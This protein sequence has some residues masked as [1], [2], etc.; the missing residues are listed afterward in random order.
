M[1][2]RPRLTSSAD[3]KAFFERVS[4]D[5]GTGTGFVA[6]GLASRAASV[7]GVDNSPAM[8]ALADDNLADLGANN[9]T[10][11][12]GDVDAMLTEMARSCGRAAR[13][14]HPHAD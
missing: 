10:L 3:V 14:L 6:A 13:W 4:I 9:V 1:P 8:R 12:V 7:V 2:D 5:V 11:L